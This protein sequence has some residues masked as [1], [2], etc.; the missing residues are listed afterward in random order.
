MRV[1]MTLRK[2]SASVE[3][4]RRRRRAGSRAGSRSRARAA[5]LVS[6]EPSSTSP[7]TKRLRVAESIIWSSTETTEGLVSTPGLLAF[8]LEDGRKRDVATRLARSAALTVDDGV[9]K[10]PLGLQCWLASL[11]LQ[12]DW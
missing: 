12:I 2:S 8:P 5:A 7:V 11:S 4:L 3:S 6:A 10:L 1:L 9:S